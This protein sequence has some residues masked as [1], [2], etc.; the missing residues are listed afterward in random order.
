MSIAH[1]ACDLDIRKVCPLVHRSCYLLL[2]QTFILPGGTHRAPLV[3]TFS[4]ILC[5]ELPR[6][7]VALMII[8]CYCIP[9]FLKQDQVVVVLDEH[10]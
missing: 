4:A 2:S 6:V 5:S 10:M 7:V 1:L 3:V 9:L 8:L